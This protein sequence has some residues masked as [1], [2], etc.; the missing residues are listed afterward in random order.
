MPQSPPGTFPNFP[1]KHAHDAFFSPQD[2]LAYARQLGIVPDFAIPDGVIFCFQNSLLRHIAQQYA[3]EPV[4]MFAGTFYLLPAFD[5]RIAVSGGFGIGAPA[6]TTILEELIAVGVRRYISVGTAG[7]LAR[8][9]QIG[10]LVVCERAIRDEGVSHHYLPP[11][12]YAEASHELT[13]R[14]ALTLRQAGLD[15]VLGASWTIDTP[16]R[17]T[18]EE[19][20]HYQAEGVLCVEMEAAALFAVAEHRGVEMAAAFAMSDSLADLVWNPQFHAG[21]TEASLNRLFAGAV[22]A[23][24]GGT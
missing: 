24:L 6:V 23:L 18:V 16:Y 14:F 3:V 4:S 13:Q 21:E 11:A 19:A 1:G 5:R 20:R 22:E 7:A 10:D 9:L 8:G 12:R 17:E 2:Y 15:P